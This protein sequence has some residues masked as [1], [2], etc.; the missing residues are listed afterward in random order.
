MEQRTHFEA[1]HSVAERF[2][3]MVYR[4]ALSYT[5]SRSDAED[6]MQEVFLRFIKYK[7]AFNDAEHEK[8]WFI[9]ATT[10]AAK[11]FLTSPWRKRMILLPDDKIKKR[12]R[13]N[14]LDDSPLAEALAKLCKKQRVCIHLFYYEGYS[15][16]EI[17][18]LTDA[19]EGTVKSW[20]HRAR[21][22]LKKE[23]GNTYF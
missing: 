10:N 17:A 23:L 6:I 1:A 14:A 22:N 20:L 18:G 2:G 7:P 3:D 11:T 4:V 16:S 21:E 5:H 8:A 12:S 9:K 13:E 19:K 15:I